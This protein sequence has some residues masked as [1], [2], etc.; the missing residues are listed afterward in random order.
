VGRPLDTAASSIA[1]RLDTDLNTHLD[2]ESES[3]RQ[4]GSKL[5][6]RRA[7]ELA[8]S[9]GDIPPIV[10]T[11]DFNSRPDSFTYRNFVAAGFADTYLAAGN[12]DARDAN[13]F[14][15]IEGERFRDAHS[16]H[17]P[18]R[19]D[20]I[21]LKDPRDRL[22]TESHEIVRDRDERKGLYPSDHYPALAE[23]VPTV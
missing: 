21:L 12:E 7:E 10:V 18:R 13:T 2:H 15:A 11:G 8:D 19:I 6:R 22:R 5:I 16:E 23:F 1:A 14:H 3:A 17:G 9:L 20:W 4:E